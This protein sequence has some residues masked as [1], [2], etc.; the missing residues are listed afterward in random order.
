[1]TRRTKPPARCGS[2]S[3]PARHRREGTPVCEP[4]KVARREYESTYRASRRTSPVSDLAY[5]GKWVRVGLILRPER[6]AA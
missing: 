3:G 6:R 4:C 2:P 5:T 1:M